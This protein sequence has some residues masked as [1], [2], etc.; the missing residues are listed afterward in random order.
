MSSII[1][2]QQFLQEASVNSYGWFNASGALPVEIYP[3]DF[4]FRD[5]ADGF[6]K[7]MA[8][9]TTANYPALTDQWLLQRFAKKYFAGLADFGKRANDLNT[10]NVLLATD[11]VYQ[12]KLQ[13][14]G[15]A[16][17]G[18]LLAVGLA[19][20]N[21]GCLSDT[22]Y[23]LSSDG[24]GVD[25]ALAVGKVVTD[26]YFSTATTL[27]KARLTSTLIGHAQSNLVESGTLNAV[28]PF[29]N[30]GAPGGS[31]PYTLAYT[32]NQKLPAG[33]VV[34]DWQALV[35]AAFAGT[36]I[37]AAT[38][39]VGTGASAGAFSQTTNGSVFAKGVLSSLP[40]VASA[41]V[42]TE[43]APVVTITVTGGNTPNAGS[44]TVAIRYK[45]P[46]SP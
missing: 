7:P 28:I 15:T 17:I 10:T 34:T 37:T 18:D 40:P 13:A 46:L 5:P 23:N 44:V 20:G 25:P 36:G 2:T 33:A 19:P 41:A 42:A 1:P 38:L 24:G 35:T 3:G 39:Q 30:L 12:T 21:A 31:G 8:Y 22:V 27:L 43:T 9:L 32:L 45:C 6:V 11:V 4:L 26:E 16:N 14:S 29:G